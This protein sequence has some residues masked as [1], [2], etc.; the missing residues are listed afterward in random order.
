MPGVG[1]SVDLAIDSTTYEMT[2]YLKNSSNQVISYDSINLPLE[3]IDYTS[4]SN[5]P[6]I[7]NVTLTGNKTTSDLGISY[8]DLANKPTI[9]TKTSDLNNDSGFITNTLDDNLDANTFNITNVSNINASH[10]NLNSGGTSTS[11]DSIVLA[12]QSAVTQ[13]GTDK[14]DKLTAGTNITIDANNVISATGGGTSD[15]TDLENKPS[16]NNVT[17]TGNKSLSDLG[18]TDTTYTAGTN[19]SI[20]ANNEISATDTTYSNATTSVA[21]LMST[22]D[23]AKVDDLY[24]IKQITAS[25]VRI[26]DLDDGAYLLPANCTIYYYGSTNTSTYKALASSVVMWVLSAGTTYKYFFMDGSPNGDTFRYI[27][28]G[29]STSGAGALNEKNLASLLTNIS[30]YVKDN[31]TYNTSGTNYA[32]SAYQGYLLN[33]NKADNTAFTGTDGTNAGVKGLVPAPTTSDTGKYLKSDGTWATVSGGGGIQALNPNY[34]T[35]INL[36]ETSA[37]F[38]KILYSNSSVALYYT[39]TSSIS[40]D[41][42]AYISI[43]DVEDEYGDAMKYFYLFNPPSGDIDSGTNTYDGNL[44]DF[45]VGWTAKHSNNTVNGSRKIVKFGNIQWKSALVTSINSSSTDSTYPSAKCVYDAMPKI[46]YGTTDIGTG[47][48]L[49]DGTLY[50]VYE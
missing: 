14:Q 30:S 4:L 25:S 19:V 18:I 7:N 49:A 37:G 23:K 48:T 21:G 11:L 46:T 12:N 29:Y 16:I 38:Y 47:A 22:T 43:I 50:F 44:N 13:L 31:L 39:S 26:W 5:K 15:Y 40:V 6:S 36:Y 28:A 17:L 34:E 35:N 20:S 33:Q 24:K 42:E 2:L 3:S 41:S 27:Y 9:P 10:F 1:A 32:L 8:T 45:Y